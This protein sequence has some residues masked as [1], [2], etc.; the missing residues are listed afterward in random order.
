MR[1]FADAAE[2][3]AI[4]AR[5]HAEAHIA[6]GCVE[7]ELQR[8]LEATKRTVTILGA[9]QSC[10][11]FNLERTLTGSQTSEVEYQTIYRCSG[12]NGMIEHQAAGTSLSPVRLA[13][14]DVRVAELRVLAAQTV[15]E[16]WHRRPTPAVPAADIAEARSQLRRLFAARG[17][18]F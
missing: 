12:R 3:P 10:F 13:A 17:Y 6:K 14:I 9:Q 5:L 15:V 1:E 2:V 4:A 7:A 8:E 18:R 11:N 16:Y